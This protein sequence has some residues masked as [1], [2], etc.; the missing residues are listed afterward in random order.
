MEAEQKQIRTERS[1][2]E[3]ARL[4]LVV[5]RDAGAPNAAARARR[6]RASDT[7]ERLRDT[8]SVGGT[9]QRSKH[10]ELLLLLL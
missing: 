3:G 8:R 6:R 5:V 7:P 4:A 10:G 9:C 1:V 2:M